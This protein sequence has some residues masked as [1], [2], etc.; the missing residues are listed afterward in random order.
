M[1]TALDSRSADACSVL[2]PLDSVTATV[3][4]DALAA[5]SISTAAL[6]AARSIS[7]GEISFD[8]V[9]ATT[10]LD[11]LEA[12]DAC[13]ARAV[14]AALGALDAST[15]KAV[16]D[17]HNE[18]APDPSSAH[19]RHTMFV[20]LQA[21]HQA[22][23]V[24]KGEAWQKRS[25]D[26]RDSWKKSP[27]KPEQKKLDHVPPPPRSP[28]PSTDEAAPKTKRRGRGPGKKNKTITA[29]QKACGVTKPKR[30]GRGPG[31]IRPVD[32]KGIP[33]RMPVKDWDAK[34]S[35]EKAKYRDPRRPP[36]F[37]YELWLK[38]SEE[39][40]EQKAVLSV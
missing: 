2:V 25:L 3:A 38:L 17:K 28:M 22:A 27:L 19:D 30:R 5:L 21:R 36:F 32:R 7:T 13:N 9:T 23:Q 33:A 11:V 10:T 37:P 1:S 4:L 40:K 14:L 8:S 15:A 39:E 20:A 31:K 35:E 29:L 16:L 24:E 6:L 18:L 34:S 12:L 26:T